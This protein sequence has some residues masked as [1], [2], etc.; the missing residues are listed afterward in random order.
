MAFIDSVFELSEEYSDLA[1]E[2]EDVEVIE[3]FFEEVDSVI[4]N[5]E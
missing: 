3:D 2:F 5:D 1:E 4:D